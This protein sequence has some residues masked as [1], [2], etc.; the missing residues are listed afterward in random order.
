[1]VKI[2]RLILTVAVGLVLLTAFLLVLLS[3]VVTANTPV[4]NASRDAQADQ[5]SHGAKDD[6]GIHEG[7]QEPQSQRRDTHRASLPHVA[8]ARFAPSSP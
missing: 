8:H 1:L 2:D 4:H 6:R 5:S 3:A 7:R